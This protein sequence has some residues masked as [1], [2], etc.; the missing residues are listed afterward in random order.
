MSK[1]KLCS[2]CLIWEQEDLLE[3]IKR[4]NL[5]MRHGRRGR[6]GASGVCAYSGEEHI[7][8]RDTL[9]KLYTGLV[10]VIQRLSREQH[11][12]SPW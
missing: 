1:V 8:A 10:E 4:L 3:G 6:P 7:C 12:L 2:R 9:E 5:D 11:R